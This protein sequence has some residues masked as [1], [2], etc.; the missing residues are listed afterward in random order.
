MKPQPHAERPPAAT[1]H[2]R[3]LTAAIILAWIAW[4]ALDFFLHA[5]VLAWLWTAP[6]PALL[7]PRDL[8]VRIPLGYGSFLLMVIL[9]AW[10][11]VRLEARSARRSAL[12]GLTV[13]ALTSASFML[14]LGSISTIPVLLLL[15]WGMMQTAEMTIAGAVLGAALSARRLRWLVIGVAALAIA[16]IAIAI[17]LQSL[18]LAPM[19]PQPP[20]VSAS[21]ALSPSLH[22]RGGRSAIAG[23][24]ATRRGGSTSAQLPGGTS[25]PN[26]IS[27]DPAPAGPI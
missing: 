15:V 14:G 24:E 5:G 6:H 2:R 9:L 20:P 3:R 4:L 27:L 22:A 26:R 18:G 12:L 16:C 25:F 21:S 7:P 1:P 17:A 23:P 10:L 11:A 19:P 8:A 13:G